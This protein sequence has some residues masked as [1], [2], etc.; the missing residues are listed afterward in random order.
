MGFI[1]YRIELLNP[2][3]RTHGPSLLIDAD[4]LTPRVFLSTPIARKS[5]DKSWKS[6]HALRYHAADL[7]HLL[8]PDISQHSQLF[9]LCFLAMLTSYIKIKEVEKKLCSSS[10][11]ISFPNRWSLPWKRRGV[12]QVGWPLS[13]VSERKLRWGSCSDRANKHSSNF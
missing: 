11:L 2:K 9:P 6:L 12:A 4:S 10:C 7:N 8:W 13:G 5:C 3:R 1:L